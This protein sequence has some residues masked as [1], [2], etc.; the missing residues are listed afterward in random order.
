MY[1]KGLIE[2]PF[3]DP[4]SQLDRIVINLRKVARSA[5]YP[6]E[7]TKAKAIAIIEQARKQGVV[8]GKG[9]AGLAAAALYMGS[10]RLIPQA[11]LAAAASVTEVTVRNNYKARSRSWNLVIALAYPWAKDSDK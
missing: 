3:S 1:E 6:S 2:V 5:T 7:E 4:I 9:P 8:A 10:S 11:E